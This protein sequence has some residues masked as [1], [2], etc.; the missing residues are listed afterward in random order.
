M[1][2]CMFAVL[3][4]LL[5]LSLFF[6]FLNI[7]IYMIV[8]VLCPF[9]GFTHRNITQ[10]FIANSKKWAAAA[11]RHDCEIPEIQMPVGPAAFDKAAVNHALSEVS[12]LMHEG[13]PIMVRQQASLSLSLSLI[14]SKRVRV[15]SL[16]VCL[17]A[18][19]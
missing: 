5:M 12:R 6:F 9:L 4:A 11:G 18:C 8:S 19:L 17:L 3:V 14:M 16:S 15:S 2:T 7:Y 1:L 13:E 10:A